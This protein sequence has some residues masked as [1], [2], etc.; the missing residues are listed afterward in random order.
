MSFGTFNANQYQPIQDVGSS[1]PPGR[2]Q[3]NITGAEIKQNKEKTG[4]FLAVEFTTPAGKIINRYNLWHTNE[5]TVD[6]ARKQLSTLCRATGRYELNFDNTQI[7]AYGLGGG[8]CQIEVVPQKDKEGKE[9][10][11]TEIKMILDMAGNDPT[12]PNQGQQQAP[13]Q[14]QPQ[15]GW[16]QP[17]QQA[18]PPQQGGWNNNQQPANNQPSPN[19]G[20]PQG[21]QPQQQGTQQQPAQ[22]GWTPGPTQGGGGPTPPWGR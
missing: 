6:I 9:T 10:G 4:G 2:F 3:A 14:T 16:Q 17:Q 22:Q 8:Q 18:N 11:Y 5:T 7:P 15:G 20:W 13:Q 21:G 1:H 12:K 19:Q